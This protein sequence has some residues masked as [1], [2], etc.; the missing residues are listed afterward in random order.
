MSSFIQLLFLL[1]LLGANASVRAFWGVLLLKVGGVPPNLEACQLRRPALSGIS[2][3][4]AE[5]GHRQGEVMG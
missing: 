5:S 4:P 1:F 3:H 2:T